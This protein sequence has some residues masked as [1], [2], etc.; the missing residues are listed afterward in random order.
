MKPISDLVMKHAGKRIC[1]MGG[2][3]AL[4]EDLK[5]VD[6]DIWISSN[7]H[8]AKLRPVDYIVALDDIHTVH[9]THMSKHLRQFS[10]APII[11]VWHWGD[12]QISRCP[13]Y[14][15]LSMSGVVASWVA[16]LMGGH[17]VIM[18]GFDC[19]GGDKRIVDQHENYIKH[20]KCEVRVVSGVLTKFYK[21]YDPNEKFAPYVIP[22]LLA[23]EVEDTVKV[24]L[25]K[26]V[27]KFEHLPIG[28]II[29]V[30][31]H[32]YRLQIKHG[33]LVEV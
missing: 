18:A 26:P 29:N 9:K 10:D 28:S 31:R 25:A 5:H 21:Q 4:A 8:G 1:V 22:T 24:R 20:V 32:E 7:E 12:Y 6:A 17:P 16:Y 13:S 14:P 30:N 19:Y 15:K 3:K 23:D 33:S 2:G 11:N 27:D